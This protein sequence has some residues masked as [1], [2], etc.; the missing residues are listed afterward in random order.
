VTDVENRATAV[1]PQVFDIGIA[2]I[3]NHDRREAAT[4]TDVDE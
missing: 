4:N 3:S 1:T 2:T